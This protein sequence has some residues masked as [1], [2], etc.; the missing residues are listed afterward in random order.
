MLLLGIV[1]AG[2][3][4]SVQSVQKNMLEVTP[5]AI[6]FGTVDPESGIKHARLTL[7]NVGKSPLQILNVAT[8]CGCTEG[9]VAKNTLA[10]DETTT[11]SARFDPAMHVGDAAGDI[12]HII[13]VQT[14]D[15][16]YEE[17]GV[18]M[19]AFIQPNK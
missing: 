15:P 8:S 2:G 6:D 4:A 17:T 19:R 11:L 7:R 16:N 10:P 1:I 12:Y 9:N 5:Q 3:C 13:Y 18:E 14:D